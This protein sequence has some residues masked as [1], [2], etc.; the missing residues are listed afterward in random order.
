MKKLLI[1]LAFLGTLSPAVSQQYGYKWRFGLSAGT[2]NYYGDI[3]PIGIRNF[4]DFTK[5]YD[6]YE[7][8]TDRLSYQ[9]SMEYAL[10][11]SVGLMLTAGSYQF[12]SGDRLVKNDGSLYLDGENFDRALNFQTNLFDAGLSFV[13]KP[14]NNW[15]LSGKSF[16]APYITLG[17]GFQ[18]FEVFGDLLNANGSRYDYTNSSLIPDG[19]F[20]TKLRGLE[21]ELPGGYSKTSFYANLGLGFRIRLSKGIEIFAQSDFKRAATDYLDDVSGPYRTTYEN[22][23]QRY[24]ARPGTNTSSADQP[25]RGNPDG[26]SDWYIYHGMGIK[27]SFGANKKSFTPP[28]IQRQF[29]YVP[30][31][32]IKKQMEPVDSVEKVAPKTLPES[33]VNYF[34][35]IQLPGWQKMNAGGTIRIDSSGL[36]A[37]EFFKDSISSQRE[38]IRMELLETTEEMDQLENRMEMIAKDSTLS[39]SVKQ[40]RVLELENERSYSMGK[41]TSLNF[42]DSELKAKQ[43]SLGTVSKDRFKTPVD[44]AGMVNQLL[45]YPGQVSK[46]LYLSSGEAQI[47]LQDDKASL[48][49]MD[50]VLNVKTEVR[51]TDFPT[52]TQDQETV[53]KSKKSTSPTPSEDMMSRADFEAKMDQFKSEMLQAQAV[54]DSAMMRV[55]ASKL[56]SQQVT[57]SQNLRREALTAKTEGEELKEQRKLELERQK[58][59]IFEE[60]N[61]RLEQQRLAAGAA[62]TTATITPSSKDRSLEE[63]LAKRDSIWIDQIQADSILIDSLQRLVATPKVEVKT[64]TVYIEKKVDSLTYSLLSEIEVYF[65]INQTSLT[66]AEKEKLIQVKNMLNSFPELKVDLRGFADNTGSIAYNLRISEKRVN[67]VRDYLTSLGINPTRINSNVGGL[68]IRGKSKGS[69]DT[70]RKVEVRFKEK[71]E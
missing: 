16:L 10:G 39:D 30:Q 4:K 21:T 54:R 1:L 56:S 35:V 51:K 32:L 13:F 61:K 38:E 58:Q 44:T 24:A 12:G 23:F 37:H 70:D 67:A 43:D 25:Y 68:I 63:E 31:A 20:E 48:S 33:T 3:R 36:A 2:T 42:L 34:T 55:F 46:I 41:I 19:T 15:L 52:K 49:T 59:E 8:Y 14:D 29:T 65:G 28:V 22:D 53:L 57:D 18:S 17:A 66:D 50:S 60:R 47:L 64:D 71:V 40:S 7:H 27:F 9:A 6:S 5:L 69:V 26:R 45:I 62:T 11:N